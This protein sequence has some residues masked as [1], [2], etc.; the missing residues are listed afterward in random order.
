MSKAYARLAWQDMTGE[1][2]RAKKGD[3]VAQLVAA[4]AVETGWLPPSLRT[5]AYA[6]PAFT[7]AA[8]PEA[9]ND[10]AADDVAAVAAE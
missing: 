6:G 2:L 10:D 8:E 9:D 7:S 4:K 5:G 3:D 1:K